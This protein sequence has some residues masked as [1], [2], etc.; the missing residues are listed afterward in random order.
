ERWLSQPISLN[1]EPILID[2]E[3]L[4]PLERF[5]EITGHEDVSELIQ[6]ENFDVFAIITNMLGSLGGL[7]G[8][9]F[10]V[11]GGFFNTVVN[12]GFLIVI[13]FY[14]MRDGEYF[15]EQI[16]NVAPPSYQGDVRRLLFEL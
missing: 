15:I 12:I 10:G 14:M 11:L 9:A 3:P 5:Q 16:V 8:P 7:T 2:G 1:G 13:M 4:I 6:L